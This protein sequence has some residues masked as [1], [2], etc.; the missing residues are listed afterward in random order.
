MKKGALFELAVNKYF[1]SLGWQTRKLGSFQG[2]NDIG[3]I[4]GIPGWV[5]QCRNV[6]LAS[7]GASCADA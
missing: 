6:G 4:D 2:S 1:Q 7:F 5:V 3:D